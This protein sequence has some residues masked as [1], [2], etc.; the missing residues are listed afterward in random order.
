MKRNAAFLLSFALLTLS[1]LVVS[2]VAAQ[3]A[4]AKPLTVE[5][6]QQPGGLGGRGPET[7]EWSPDGTKFSFV[8]RDEKGDRRTVVY[9]H[10]DRREEGAGRRGKAGL[11]R[12][13]RGQG[14][15]RAG[16][17][18]FE[19][20]CRGCLSV[21]AGLQ[22]LMFDSLGA[23]ALDLASQT[24]VSV[25]SPPTRATTPSFSQM[26]VISP[27]SETQSV[28]SPLSGRARSS[29]P[30]IPPRTCLTAISTGSIPKSWECAAI[31][32]GRPTVKK[33]YFSTWMKP[34]SDLSHHGL[35]DHAS[36]GRRAEVPQGG[37]SEPGGEV[38]RGGCG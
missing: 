22:H 30:T 21:G 24:G 4:P 2:P 32:S 3:T 7:T 33:W 1:L 9:R 25:L 35:D 16:K 17:G 36:V 38:G 20:L 29:S 37:R 26:E 31:I 18:T 15:E 5:T 14:E 19:A 28:C 13:R 10:G 11:A 34:M 27:T 8:Q 6:L 12:S 23:M